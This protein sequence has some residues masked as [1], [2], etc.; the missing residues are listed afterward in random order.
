MTG[1]YA[2][3]NGL[4]DAAAFAASAARPFAPQGPMI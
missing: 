1:E 3:G 2:F 4:A